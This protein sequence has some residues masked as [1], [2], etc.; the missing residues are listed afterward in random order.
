MKRFICSI[1]SALT[2]ISAFAAIYETNDIQRANLK[3]VD[4]WTALQA[5][6]GDAVVERALRL[7]KKA[8]EVVVLAEMCDVADGVTLEFPIIGELSDRDYE[9][10]FRTFAK[11]GSIAKAIEALGVPRGKNVDFRAMSFW[12]K[13]ERISVEVAP[14]A[15]TNTAYKPIQSFIIDMQTRAPLALNYFIY[16]GSPDDPESKDGVRLCDAIAPNSVLSSYNEPQTVLDM[17]MRCPQSD[18]YERFLLAPGAKLKPFGLYKLRFRPLLREDGARHVRN[19]TLKIKGAEAGVAYDLVLDG[20][21]SRTLTAQGIIAE[22]KKAVQD[23]FDPF[24]EIVFDDGVSLATAIEQAQMLA[25]LEGDKGIRVSPPDA[26]S[27]YYK[28]FMPSPAWRTVKDRPSQPWEIHF[29]IET[30]GA[31]IIRMVKTLEDWTSTDSLDPILSFKNFTASTPQEAASTILKNGAG[32][33]VLLIFA[34]AK[35]PLSAIM[36][37]IRLLRKTHPTVYFF[38][39]E[40]K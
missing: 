6:A 22:M 17:P 32:L 20:K 8:G 21:S 38:T 40:G 19:Y 35:T 27:V 26:N 1:A 31:P 11:P 3:C 2:A 39:E 28:G 23:G 15:T 7:D 16:C 18:V 13:G 10:L 9:A 33:P 29:G 30:N 14:F 36:P 37:T 4:E 25:L 24:V 34:P 5:K 12:P